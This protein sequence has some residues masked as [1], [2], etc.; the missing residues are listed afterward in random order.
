[1]TCENTRLHLSGGY[2]EDLNIIQRLLEDPIFKVV[3]SVLCLQKNN[4]RPAEQLSVATGS[5]HVGNRQNLGSEPQTAHTVFV[6]DVAAAR[7]ISTAET[8][9][10]AKSTVCN[11]SS[12]I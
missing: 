3:H 5:G 4:G 6:T 12:W 1:M 10:L 11:T 2:L 7:L 8:S 9:C